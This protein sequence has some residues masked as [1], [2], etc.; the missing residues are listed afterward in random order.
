MYK[1][2]R[3]EIRDLFIAF[4]VLSFCFAISNV[5]FDFHGIISILPIVMI[6]VGI[7]FL[8]HEIGDKFMAMKLGYDAE[9]KLWPLGLLIAF[10]TAL[11]G[12]VFASPGE[13]H[14]I[15]G[16]IDDEKNGKIAVAGPL[17]NMILA[18][19]FIVIAALIYPFSIHSDILNLIYLI[20]TVGF[21]VN[22]FL[23]TFNMFPIYSLDGIKVLKWNFVIW[24][25]VFT[26]AA[27]MMLISIT[28]GAENMV[29]LLLS[30]VPV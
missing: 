15:S 26:V 30:G 10:V 18:V 5:K 29:K 7:G 4:V 9:F 22:S 27:I 6:G 28:I 2:T 3:N 1:F 8:F 17:A 16:N 19:L 14:I 25:V 13:T 20:C 23:A 12:I 21:S 11:I 24:A